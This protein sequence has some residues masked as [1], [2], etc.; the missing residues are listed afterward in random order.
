VHFTSFILFV[1]ALPVV[2]V[3]A[4]ILVVMAGLLRN[5]HGRPGRLNREQTE[6]LQEIYRGLERMEK[7]IESLE[8]IVLEDPAAGPAADANGKEPDH[9]PS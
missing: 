1:L 5:D 2:A 6:L 9:D 3:I 8:T 7:R 4:G